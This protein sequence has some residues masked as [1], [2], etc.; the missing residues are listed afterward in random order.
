M[1]D[2]NIDNGQGNV[3]KGTTN[4]IV[5]NGNVFN[6]AT[7]IIAGNDNDRYKDKKEVQYTAKQMRESRFYDSE[8]EDDDEDDE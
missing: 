4:V 2:K 1:G 6:G 5:G 7:N 8:R 3:F